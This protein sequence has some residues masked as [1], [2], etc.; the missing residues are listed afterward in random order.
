MGELKNCYTIFTTFMNTLSLFFGFVFLCFS[1]IKLQNVHITKQL[2]YRRTFEAKKKNNFVNDTTSIFDVTTIH[3]IWT[4]FENKQKQC[5]FNLCLSVTFKCYLWQ[6][7]LQFIALF[8]FKN[9]K[10]VTKTVA[11]M[12][13]KTLTTNSNKK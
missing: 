12:V 11:K 4:I 13:T 8:N 3:N 2:N 7:W 5:I 6:L 9:I 1:I 10:L